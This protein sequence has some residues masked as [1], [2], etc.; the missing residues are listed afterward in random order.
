MT[1]ITISAFQICLIIAPILIVLLTFF[2][3]IFVL[4]EIIS[5]VKTKNNI[6]KFLKVDFSIITNNMTSKEVRKKIKLKPISKN[7]F[8]YVYGC[9][10]NITNGYIVKEKIILF[11][12]NIVIKIEESSQTTYIGKSKWN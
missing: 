11:E 10:Q 8:V 2:I 9:I 12:N 6:K 1:E 5:N 3:C 7:E 4:I